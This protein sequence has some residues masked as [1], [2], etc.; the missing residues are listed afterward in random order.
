[1]RKGRIGN[2]EKHQKYDNTL[3]KGLKIVNMHNKK[4][5]IEREK[6]K[7]KL[8]PKES[9]YKKFRSII[10]G[11]GTSVIIL[12]TVLIIYFGPLIGISLNRN[13]GID[14]KKRID[15]VVTDADIYATYCSELLIYSNQKISTYNN[16]GHKTWQYDLTTNYTP[17]VY[18][19]KSFMVIT[20]NS[21]GNIYLFED[22]KEIL[23]VKIEGQINEVF[24][25]EYGNYVVEY[26]T[27]GYKKVLGVYSK[28]G[29]NL[30]NVYLSSNAILDVKIMDNGNKLLIFQINSSTFKTGINICVVDSTNETEVKTIARIDNNFMF[31]LT[32]Q[33]S[34]IIMLLDDKMV[35]CNMDTGC[36]TDICSFD[37]SQLMFIS[38]SNNYYTMLS[39]E[40]KE[41]NM[42]EYSIV[43]NR[44]DNTK[45]SNLK[46]TD[47]PK[48]MKNSSVL[49]Y[50]LY[51]DSL[52]VVNKWGV[53]VKNVHIDFPPKEVVIFN[54]SKSIAL[55]YT[56]KVYIVNI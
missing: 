2:S 54:N 55:V 12:I 52:K 32:I 10:V 11:I 5:S 46:I 13:V 53:E 1:M 43:S 56:N 35:K 20:N 17:S 47:S 45:I 15:I 42:S 14:E 39:K 41:Q 28:N 25:D 8:V 37:S 24:L 33:N 29:K 19:N 23:N 50:L 21:T 7:L 26:S 40:L 48:L 51:Q 4:L 31:D 3:N 27:S 6:R 38:L 22:K 34:N 49:N 36:I 30:Y 18:I 44:F 16:R 9:E